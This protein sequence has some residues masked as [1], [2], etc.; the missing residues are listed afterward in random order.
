M[1]LLSKIAKQRRN[2]AYRVRNK[3]RGTTTRPRLTVFRSNKH[4]YAQIINDQTGMTLVSASTAEKAVCSADENGGNVA[5]AT[6]VGKIL[7]ERA[8][9]KGIV[10]IAFD[11][12]SY[13]Y[14]GR[15][16]ALANAARAEGLN[17]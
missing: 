1:K 13:R 10:D 7:A 9:E 12:G 17:F 6:K 15:I 4:I 8:K 5:S 14:H 2:R 11:R 16:A 3:I